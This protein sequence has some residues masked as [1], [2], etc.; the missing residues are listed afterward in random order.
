LH[1]TGS[2]EHNIKMRGIAKS[3]GLK[4]NQRNIE[5]V[6]RGKVIFFKT[7]E[8]RSF[9]KASVLERITICSPE[10]A[11]QSTSRSTATAIPSETLSSIRLV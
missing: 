8:R 3:R 4:L 9:S 2:K 6:E 10:F 11:N 7:W 1:F 5:I